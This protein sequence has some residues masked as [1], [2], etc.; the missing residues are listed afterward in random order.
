MKFRIGV[1][2]KKMASK[3]SFVKIGTVKSY[4]LT[5]VS[6]FLS[7]LPT[8][9]FLIEILPKNYARNA[10]KVLQVTYKPVLDGRT[11]RCDVNESTLIMFRENL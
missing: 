11:V 3:A 4:L 8:F 2:H 7:V 10:V 5:A 1:L 6:T 9:I